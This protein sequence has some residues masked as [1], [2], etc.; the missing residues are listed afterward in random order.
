MVGTDFVY[1]VDETRHWSLYDDFLTA[2]LPDRVAEVLAV[3][4]EA[5]LVDIAASRAI[6]IETKDG[7]C[8]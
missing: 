2:R 5:N 3:K 1:Q 8:L 7:Q 6:A 4:D